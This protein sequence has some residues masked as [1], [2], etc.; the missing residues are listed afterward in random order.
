MVVIALVFVKIFG[1]K[2]RSNWLER[3][4]KNK[5]KRNFAQLIVSN[6]ITNNFFGSLMSR[7]FVWYTIRR[8]N[9]ESKFWPHKPFS[10]TRWCPSQ[11]KTRKSASRGR[12]PMEQLLESIFRPF[13][14]FQKFQFFRVPSEK[15]RFWWP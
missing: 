11:I 15:L 1:W 13:N 9:V 5:K 6:I 3:S 4:L 7:A 14:F 2:K 12:F 10:A 8:N